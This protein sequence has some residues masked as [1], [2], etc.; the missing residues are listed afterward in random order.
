M[1]PVKW[2]ATQRVEDLGLRFGEPLEVSMGSMAK[3][4]M[5]D[6]E[7]MGKVVTGM[8]VAKMTTGRVKALSIAV[9]D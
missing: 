3:T 1:A 5:P 8:M 6:V 4:R 7:C 9:M 2:L